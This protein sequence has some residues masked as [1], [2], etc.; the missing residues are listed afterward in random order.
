MPDLQMVDCVA[1]V[2]PLYI[3]GRASGAMRASMSPL[4]QA[5]TRVLHAPS[6][7]RYSAPDWQL[8]EP[9][10]YELPFNTQLFAATSGFSTQAIPNPLHC[11]SSHRYWL[12]DW[13]TADAWEYVVALYLHP[14]SPN[15]EPKG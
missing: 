7:H 3:Q 14:S 12:P 10:E 9:G 13:Q 6:S 2:A 8:A 4:L 11:P 5:T 15:S 1:A